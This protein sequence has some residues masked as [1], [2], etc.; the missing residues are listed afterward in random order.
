MKN[1]LRNKLFIAGL[2]LIGAC[3]DLDEED[4]LYDTVTSQSFYKNEQELLSAIGGAYSNLYGSF[5]NAD[6]I[7]PMY[8]VTSDEIVVP[9][10]G[11]DWGDGGHWVR[12]KRHTYTPQD[13]RITSTWTFLY[14]GVNTCNRVLATL[15]PL[16][17]D[18]SKAFIA[19][20]KLVYQAFTKM[21]GYENLMKLV[22]KWKKIS[23]T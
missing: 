22:E 16:G 4:V 21:E 1:I 17:T 10:R 7:W 15:E 12:L 6:N 18:A 19:E 11:A 23:C 2:L 14:R 8:E 13:P 9:T 20:L 5:G 3:T